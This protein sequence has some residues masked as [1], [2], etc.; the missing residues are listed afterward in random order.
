MKEIEDKA[1]TESD[2]SFIEQMARGLIGV[3]TD[4]L[5]DRG[6]ETFHQF[7]D[8][9]WEMEGL[10]QAAEIGEEDERFEVRVD[11]KGSVHVWGDAPAAVEL[12]VKAMAALVGPYLDANCE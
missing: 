5:E 10:R 3:A 6:W 2:A 11:A 12:L 1:Y 4:A 7:R 8:S 9:Y